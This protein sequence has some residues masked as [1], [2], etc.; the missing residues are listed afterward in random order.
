MGHCFC[1]K[2]SLFVEIFHKIQFVWPHF[3][4]SPTQ[5]KIQTE[6]GKGKTGNYRHHRISGQYKNISFKGT[7]P[8]IMWIALLTCWDI[9]Q[10]IL[11]E[12]LFIYIQINQRTE[13]PT[14]VIISLNGSYVHLLKFPANSQDLL[15]NNAMP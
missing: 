4:L 2:I 13:K 7:I 11:Q 5:T 10:A 6:R 9:Y 1:L 14:S 15:W 12:V 8:F 3:V